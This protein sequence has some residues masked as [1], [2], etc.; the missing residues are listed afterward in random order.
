MRL[1]LSAFLLPITLAAA[2]TSVQIDDRRDIASGQAYG[3]AGVYER[4]T[5]KARFAIDPN[6][7]ANAAIVD[8][9]LAPRNAKG[10]VEFTADIHILKPRDLTKSNGTILF[11]VSNRGG[12]SLLRT[13]NLS[14]A[15][16]EFGDGFLLKAGYTL[17]WVG[18]QYDVA[19]RPGLIRIDVPVV[20]G[21][22]GLVREDFQCTERTTH[23]PITNIYP[24]VDL[25]EAAARLAVRDTTFAE[26]HPIPRSEWHFS[27]P[28]SV[29]LNR[30]C[31]PGKSYD[32]VYTAK[33]PAVAGVGAA[34]IRD[35]IS[36]L[37]SGGPAATPLLGDPKAHLERAI[38]F[39]SS[40]SGRYLRNY[41]RD[42]FNASED[43][44]PVFDTVWPHIAGSAVGSFNHRF[45]QPSPTQFYYPLE[46]FPFHDLPQKDPVT[47]R[48]AG[49][50]DRATAAKVTPKII[51]TLSSNEY[52]GRSASL[53]H[54]S[55]DGMTEAPPAPQSRIYHI[56]GT[57]H[58]GGQLPIKRAAGAMY[59]GNP[60]DL[61]PVL[62]ALL[63]AVQDWMTKGKEPPASSYAKLDQLAPIEKLRFPAIPNFVHP[64]QVRQA[65][66]LDYG[67]EFFA[68]GVITQ[69]P[70]KILGKPYPAKLPQLDA[71]GNEIGGI[72]LPTIAVPLATHLAWN[73]PDPAKYTSPE[74]LGLGG[75]HI[76]FPKT[77]A[78]RMAA[79][80]PRLSIE[81]RY[82]N[83][84]DY[85]AKVKAA[86][87]RLAKQG[88]LLPADVPLV[89]ST[90]ER[91]WDTVA[92]SGGAAHSEAQ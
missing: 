2:V 5:G 10:L 34:A 42:G 22:T 52:W 92:A 21:V 76:A 29:E 90:C 75:S 72:R 38:A 35:F 61:R 23:I 20:K 8:L 77:K 16:E 1:L 91:H 30:P 86:A 78:E 12:M 37:K 15:G 13:F 73:M 70:A 3:S 28:K 11:E 63:V 87:E 47:G 58:G 17:V 33:D 64:T 83:R 44:K 60:N 45:A 36:L 46:L 69:E 55:I 80:D 4:I 54:T 71:D 56:A 43:A 49:L 19:N 25:K 9:K 62:R 68:K 14:T 89:V 53:T 59:D 74:M 39:G 79:K 24:V 65:L 32:V 51:Y 40:Q 66:P 7:P 67:P 26:H 81:E 50:L 6:A 88:H 84:K 48:T 85:L 82:R 27:G 57:Q 41:L 31:E 18:W